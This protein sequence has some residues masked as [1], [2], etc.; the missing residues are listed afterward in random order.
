M[1]SGRWSDN[2]P[3]M[4]DCKSE[5][6]TNLEAR[7]RAE[8]PEAVLAS[9]LAHMTSSESQFYGG[10]LGKHHVI[11][12]SRTVILKSKKSSDFTKN[13]FR[14]KNSLTSSSTAGQ[15]V[16]KIPGQKNS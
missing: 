15:K 14:K 12:R 9:S 13:L 1:D 3:D 5:A 7:V 11:P 2:H 4:S 10:D 8:D 6:A 16:L